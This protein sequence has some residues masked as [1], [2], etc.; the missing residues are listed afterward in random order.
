MDRGFHTSPRGVK[1]L[2]ALLSRDPVRGDNAGE[3]WHVTRPHGKAQ[4]EM[5]SPLVPLV[6]ERVRLGAAD[7]AA[8]VTLYH[9]LGGPAPDRLALARIEH[10]RERAAT[11]FVRDRDVDSLE[12]A[13]VRLDADERAAKVSVPPELLSP[14][15]VRQ[16]LENL[17]EWWAAVG[18]DDR[19]ALA[20]TLF[21]KIRV[22]GLRRAVIE[23]TPEAVARGLP[24]AFGLDEVEMVGARG[25]EPPAS[26]SRTMRAT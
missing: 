24:H 10:E 26:S 15:E 25:F 1:S 23:P 21:A 18:P 4:Q 19:K 22:L 20:E 16:Y 13:M 7:I 11:R 3:V 5:R 14:S 6:L 2:A 8:T 9:S 12:S 17:P